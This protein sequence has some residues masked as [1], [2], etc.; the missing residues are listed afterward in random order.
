MKRFALIAL[1]IID[2]VLF[3]AIA[4]ALGRIAGEKD[5]SCLFRTMTEAKLRQ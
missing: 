4:R 5:T 3:A 2:I 1:I